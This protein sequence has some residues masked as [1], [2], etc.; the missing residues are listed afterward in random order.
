MNTS[1]YTP[2]DNWLHLTATIVENVGFK[3]YV[4]GNLEN[5]NT[6]LGTFDFLNSSR[7]GNYIGAN[8]D[9]L[10]NITEG[11]IDCVRIWNKELSQ[12][13]VTAIATQELAGID[14]NS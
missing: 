11:Q 9:G 6:T 13:E 10:L 12:A 8:R 7:T 2:K 4:N 14:I 3:L 1:N 5:T